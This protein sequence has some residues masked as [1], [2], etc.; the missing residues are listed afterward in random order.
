MSLDNILQQGEGDIIEIKVTKRYGFDINNMKKFVDIQ[1]KDIK[2]LGC[3]VLWIAYWPVFIY[4]DI[5]IK[6]APNGVKLEEIEHEMKILQKVKGVIQP[7][8]YV[9]SDCTVV[10]YAMKKYETSSYYKCLHTDISY[11]QKLKWI[12][13]L[14]TIIKN[15]HNI[16]IYHCDI[17]RDNLVLDED[18]SI[19]LID[20]GSAKECDRTP[21][22][23]L[24]TDIKTAKLWRPNW[25]G[26]ID[27]KKYDYYS[28]CMTIG[29]L[30]TSKYPN[31]NTLGTASEFKIKYGLEF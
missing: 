24:M 12:D 20:F 17:R 6:A 28:L 22:L 16:G 18:M 5:I 23:S 1:I 8:F 14:V 29:E 27:L 31:E 13:E 3:P 26:E 21:P 10:G 30:I 9:K 4:N 19:I 15:L 2:D 11:E 7:L 25:N